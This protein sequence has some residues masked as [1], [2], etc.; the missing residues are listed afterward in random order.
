MT[1]LLDPGGTATGRCPS[2]YVTF[3]NPGRA[4]CVSSRRR[5]DCVLRNERRAIPP[6]IV[7]AGALAAALAAA[8][9]AP[10][11]VPKWQAPP[12]EESAAVS[13]L[14]DSA[15]K[16][17][18]DGASVSKVLSDPAYDDARP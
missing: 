4:L 2:G 7:L 12:G 3:A 9:A 5:I 16:A 10:A 8:A 11:Q 13:G 17:L 6:L 1:A 18:S 15:E 14:I